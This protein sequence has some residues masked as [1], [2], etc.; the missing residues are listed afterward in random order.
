MNDITRAE[1]H[2]KIRLY[3]PNPSFNAAHDILEDQHVLIVSGPPGVGK[4]T[5]AEILTYAYLAEGWDL[6]A[7]RSLDDGLTSIDD[8]K[9]QIFFF[10]DFLGKVALDRRALSQKDSDIAR[11]IRRI[12]SSKNARFILTTR[13]YILEEARHVSEY[14]ADKRLDVTK[15][16]LDVG[17][18]TREIRARILY[19]H[20]LIAQVDQ[21][22][23]AVLIQSDELL[24]V[25]D[26]KNYNPRIIEW[27]TDSV[28]L[29]NIEAFK[30]PAAFVDALDH[31]QRLWEI[32]FRTHIQ[33]RCQHLLLALFFCSEYG[34][35]IEEL[36]SSYEALHRRLCAHVWHHSHSERFRG[37]YTH[38]RGWVRVDP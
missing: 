35:E 12:Q 15:Y 21:A 30:Y 11:F 22:L 3:A 27:M 36:R 31:P 19:N 5:L 18:Y 16:T 9:K 6:S 25:V 37:G 23:I 1:I 20:L 14:L 17:V 4:T 29:K 38:S 24:R 10:D 8:T 28:H 32:A 7:I 33:P 2:A 13:A 34:I 26:H